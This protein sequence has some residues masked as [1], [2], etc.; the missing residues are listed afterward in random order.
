MPTSVI[1]QFV[2]PEGVVTGP[3]LDV[4]WES[5]ASQLNVLLNELLEQE[6][7]LPY[8][9]FVSDVEISDALGDAVS[10]AQVSTEVVLQIRYEPQAIFRVRSVTRCTATL[11]AHSEAILSVQFAPDGS[12]LAT[13]SGDTNVRLWDVSTQ[14]PRIKLEGHKSWVLVVSW[15]PDARLLASGGMD[16]KVRL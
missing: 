4:P 11:P 2:S 8:L 16:S 3:S 9:F 13:A 6:E 1:A 12:E 7:P 15:S 10:S 14:T 5:S